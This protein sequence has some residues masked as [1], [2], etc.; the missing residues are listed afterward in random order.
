[1][2]KETFLTILN[3]FEIMLN[4]WI[5]ERHLRILNPAYSMWIKAPLRRRMAN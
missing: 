4:Y 3:H 5:K 2:K 1:M